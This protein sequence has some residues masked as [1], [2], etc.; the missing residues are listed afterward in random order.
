MIKHFHQK[1]LVTNPIW[2]ICF[3]IEFVNLDTNTKFSRQK[4]HFCLRSSVQTSRIKISVLILFFV[5]ILNAKKGTWIKI[6]K[7]NANKLTHN[8]SFHFV[9]TLMAALLRSFLCFSRE[10]VISFL[11]VYGFWQNVVFAFF[12]L[13]LSG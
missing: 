1:N 10:M 7:G 6:W 9:S 2:F 8:I 13:Y 3:S 11:F 4:S 5:L 12:V